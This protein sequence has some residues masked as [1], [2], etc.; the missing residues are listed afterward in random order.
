VAYLAD[1]GGGTAITIIDKDRRVR[2]LGIF[3]RIDG[4]EYATVRAGLDTFSLRVLDM[5]GPYWLF[6]IFLGWIQVVITDPFVLLW[7]VLLIA[8]A[9]DW[10]A[11]RWV[12]RTTDPEAFS[13]KKSR[14]GLYAKALGLIVIGLLRAV[15]AIIPVLFQT[16]STGGYLSTVIGIALFIDELDSID[17]HRQDLGKRPIPMLSP[18]IARLRKLTGA[19]RRKTRAEKI[20]G[21]SKKEG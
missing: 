13:R 14:A 21:E 1:R 9:I 18:A 8:N 4:G 3:P 20:E 2:G 15:E 12:V 10:L 17:G 7:S 16:P 6:S 11:G 19:D 5:P